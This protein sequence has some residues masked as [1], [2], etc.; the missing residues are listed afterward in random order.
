MRKRSH[1]RFMPVLSIP[2]RLRAITSSLADSKPSSAEQ[3][4]LHMESCPPAP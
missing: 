3:R 2:L 1:A 4:Y